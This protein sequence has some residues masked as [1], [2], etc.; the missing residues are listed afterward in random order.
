MAAPGWRLHLLQGRL[1]DHWS[2]RVGS[3]WRL[4]FAFEDGDAM[5]SSWYSMQADYGLWQ[6]KRR[7]RAKP[8][9]ITQIGRD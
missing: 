8:C 5:P 4:T 3:H 6:A 1:A 2:V 9:P 7:F